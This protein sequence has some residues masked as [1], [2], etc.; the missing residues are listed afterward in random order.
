MI[1]LSWALCSRLSVQGT[2]SCTCTMHTVLT[3]LYKYTSPRRLPGVISTPT[4][5]KKKLF[6][7]CFKHI[8]KLFVIFYCLLNVVYAGLMK[9]IQLCSK[10]RMKCVQSSYKIRR[11]PSHKSS[12]A[13]IWIIQKQGKVQSLLYFNFCTYSNMYFSNMVC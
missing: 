1:V 11:G 6:T 13:D 7:R 3:H 9:L 4:H 10:Q 8:I 2:S 5:V 12:A